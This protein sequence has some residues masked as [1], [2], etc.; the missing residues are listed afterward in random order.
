MKL[1]KW[2]FGTLTALGVSLLVVAGA[3]SATYLPGEKIVTAL[4]T[5]DYVAVQRP[6]LDVAISAANLAN[7][8]A[9]HITGN[10]AVNTNKFTVTASSGNVASAGSI[11][12]S[13]ASGGV[14][15]AT[16]AGCAVTQGT[17]R[18][19]PVT[20]NGVTGAITL[21]SAAG[22]ATPATFQV[23]DS[24]VAATDTI[25]VNEK[26][27]TDLYEI[28]VTNVAAGSFKITS[29]TTGGTT[30]EQPVFNFTVI[31]GAAS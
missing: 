12:S 8:V 2:T 1:L 24:S 28:F 6:P 18:T 13:S 26:S 15:Y 19:T 20:C 23:N 17:N 14:G 3:Y 11:L 9:G 22:S 16:G 4:N 21:V 5:T 10:V 7:W 27:G 30:T 31:K 29:F 25:V